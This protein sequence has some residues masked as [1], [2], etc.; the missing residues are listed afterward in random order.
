MAADDADFFGAFA[1]DPLRPS[2]DL[3]LAYGVTLSE[4]DMHMSIADLMIERLG[5]RAEYADRVTIG[6][7]ELIVRDVD[8]DGHITE[9][10]LSFEPQWQPPKIPVFMSP[11]E[12]KDYLAGWI[13]K[14]RGRK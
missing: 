6:E 5:G 13:A 1:V 12:L 7:V 2:T 3:N 14:L 4:H 9:V 8:D 10:G 11:G